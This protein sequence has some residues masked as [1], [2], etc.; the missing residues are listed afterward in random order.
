VQMLI[1]GILW[2]KERSW[3]IFWFPMSALGVFL[4]KWFTRY[5]KWWFLR[6]LAWHSR[7]KP[8]RKL[9]AELLGLNGKHL[10][11]NVRI[12]KSICG[13]QL[14]TPKELAALC[15]RVPYYNFGAN[16]SLHHSRVQKEVS[17]VCH[18]FS[19]SGW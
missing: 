10:V 18:S 3:T 15:N 16:Q 2:W 5:Q 17:S 6:W 7:I 19:A 4:S 11:T 1:L 12:V 9:R 8:W 14:Q 13:D